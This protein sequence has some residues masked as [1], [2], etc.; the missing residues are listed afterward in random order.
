MTHMRNLA[1]LATL[2]DYG[3]TFRA[4]MLFAAY[5]GLWPAEL[6]MLRWTD[7]D[8]ARHAV[9]IRQSLGST[10]DVTL[11]KHDVARTATLPPRGAGCAYGDAPPG[12]RPYVFTTRTGKRFSKTSHF[13]YWHA[14]RSACGRPGM[15]FYEL[16]QFSLRRCCGSA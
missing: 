8:F 10:G 15:D 3:P 2:G 5:V 14:V 12:G 13:Y 6:F 11:P 1:V 7:V 16:R 4:C 9:R